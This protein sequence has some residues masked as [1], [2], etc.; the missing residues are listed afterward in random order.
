MSRSIISR[1]FRAVFVPLAAYEGF[2]STA[3]ANSISILSLTQG[4]VKSSLGAGTTYA[5]TGSNLNDWPLNT[6][7][8]AAHTFAISDENADFNN[9]SFGGNGNTIVAFGN[10]GGITL[11]FATPFTPNAGEKDL[12][13]FTAQAILGGS[14]SYGLNGN[15]E[16]AILVSQDDQNWYNLSGQLIANPTTYTG[17]AYSLNAPTMAYNFHT[18]AA[19]WTDGAG[20]AATTLAGLSIASFTTPMPND[21]LFNG[22]GTNAQRLS[23]TTDTTSGLPGSYDTR[24]GNSGGGNWLDVSGSGLSQIDYVRLNGDA[25]DPSTGGVRLDAVFLNSAVVPEPASAAL[26]VLAPFAL[27]GRRMRRPRTGF[28]LLQ[29]IVVIGI[30]VLL[31]G[32]LLPALHR[33]RELTK[34]VQC[35]ANLR[36]MSQAAHLY[37]VENDGRYPTAYCWA[38]GA[39]STVTFCWDL[40]TNDT[41]G[42]PT[43]IVPGLLWQSA[44]PTRVQQ[45]PSFEG[46]ANWLDDPYTGYNY[47]TSYAGHGQYESISTPA[48]IA[49]I[50][51]PATTALFGD[52]QWSGGANKFMRAPDPSP[53][54]ASFTGRWAGTQGYRHLGKTNVAFCDGHAESVSDCFTNNAD[55][56]E[57]V[58]PGTGFLSADNKMYGG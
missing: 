5:T 57:N 51:H 4:T 36:Q 54:D 45:C 13:I 58:A 42:R 10:G 28:T 25:N 35:L 16:A 55:G 6:G 11:K 14:G 20:V 8:T 53:G 41:T 38:S 47:N 50:L 33:V 3:N 24:F 43:Q 52:G 17:Q 15:M 23:F 37:G 9:N 40:T 32:L 12:G 31:M 21:N 18:G 48:R 39:S 56:A 27:L 30:I 19:A 29:L 49:S 22:T 26:L 1:G 44:D 7:G 46:S 34:S 2:A